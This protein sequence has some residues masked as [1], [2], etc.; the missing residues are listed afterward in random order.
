M[1]APAI[2]PIIV[3]TAFFFGIAGIGFFYVGKNSDDRGY[4]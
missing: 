3:V 2:V 1:A 4:V